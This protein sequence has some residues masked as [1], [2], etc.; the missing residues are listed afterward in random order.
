M[1]L[2]FSMFVMYLMNIKLRHI[3]WEISLALLVKVILLFLL[4]KLCFSQPLS[5][6][7]NKSLSTQHIL[8]SQL[9]GDHHDD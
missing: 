3:R 6:S 1:I 5:H 9:K 8:S 7:I 2:R 4:W